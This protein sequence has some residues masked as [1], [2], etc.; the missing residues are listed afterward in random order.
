MVHNNCCSSTKSAIHWKLFRMLR[1]LRC[2]TLI[3]RL[4]VLEYVSKRLSSEGRRSTP[5]LFY[6]V[7]HTSKWVELS[8]CP[9]CYACCCCIMHVDTHQ[10][11]LKMWSVTGQWESELEGVLC[12]VWTAATAMNISTAKMRHIVEYRRN[13]IERVDSTALDYW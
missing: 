4:S 8:S 9:D 5:V 6:I 13:G 1:W 12:P 10:W 11:N 7:W 2:T 3:Y